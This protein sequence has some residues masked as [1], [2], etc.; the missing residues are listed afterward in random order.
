MNLPDGIK[1][2]IHMEANQAFLE[3]PCDP[4]EDGLEQ[5]GASYQGVGEGAVPD[6]DA[7]RYIAD[8]AAWNDGTV[9]GSGA[10]KFEA[11]T[12]K[13]GLEFA[14]GMIARAANVGAVPARVAPHV[15]D[16]APLV[17]A[18]KQTLA[19]GRFDEEWL[20]ETLWG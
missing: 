5:L 7:E 4:T 1:H 9:E 10:T 12:C 18:L 2:A 17:A 15:A 6:G 14:R 20:N 11:L 3:W 16:H 19:N 8:L 13:A